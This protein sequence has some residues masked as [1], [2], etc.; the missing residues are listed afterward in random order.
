MDLEK[1]NNLDLEI[2]FGVE[3]VQEIL[4]HRFPFLL[5]DRVTEFVEGEKIRGYK[6]VTINEPFFSGH[7]PGK[8][9]MPGVLI[10]E[11]L[12]QLGAIY[13]KLTSGGAG[14][15]DLIV[16]RGA[17]T[18]RFRKPVLPGDVLEL[19]MVHISRKARIWR[20]AGTAFVDDKKVAEAVIAA[21][22]L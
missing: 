3:R 17:D 9:I 21:A 14:K 22:L 15:N 7:F 10:V 18:V 4:P 20:M 2:P 8:A 12:A 11:A 1:S 16:F 19:E 5:V 6:C 13:A